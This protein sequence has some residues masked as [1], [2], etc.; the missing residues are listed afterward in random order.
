VC[1]YVARR[2]T[3]RKEERTIQWKARTT[4]NRE[5]ERDRRKEGRRVGKLDVDEEE[6]M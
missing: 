4:I 1:Q 2:E 6:E 5:R 3:R